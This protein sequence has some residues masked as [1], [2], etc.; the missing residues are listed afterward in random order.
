MLLVEFREVLHAGIRERVLLDHR[1]TARPRDP[2]DEPLVEAHARCRRRAA[3][4]APTRHAAPDG[5]PSRNQI[6]Q[7][8]HCVA[9]VV[10]RTTPESIERRSG[11]DPIVRM[12]PYRYARS[13]VSRGS[14]VIDGHRRPTDADSD[15]A[16]RTPSRPRSSGRSR[17]VPCP[18]TRR[19]RYASRTGPSNSEGPA[20]WNVRTYPPPELRAGASGSAK[21]GALPWARRCGACASRCSRTQGGAVDHRSRGVPVRGRCVPKPSRP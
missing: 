4:R 5:S 3:R 20:V 8:W 16:R 10:S 14:A 7:A 19:G 12:M 13:S 11:P 9:S 1:R 17:C 2:P 15:G 18:Y 6:K 21:R